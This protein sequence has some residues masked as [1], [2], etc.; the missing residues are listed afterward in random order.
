MRS[1]GTQAT[2]LGQ[3]T[4]RLS[5]SAWAGIRHPY[6]TSRCA[7][8]PTCGFRDLKN[9]REFSIQRHC[10]L[11][12]PSGTWRFGRR[13]ER[14]T[15]QKVRIPI[16]IQ[17]A[18]SLNWCNPLSSRKTPLSRGFCISKALAHARNRMPLKQTDPATPSCDP[19][20]GR[21]SRY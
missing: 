11:R 8:T 4:I 5:M 10:L 12:L 13:P 20:P 1:I 19:G 9:L 7:C 17:H 15:L 16:E 3:W 14:A 2:S 6:R 18:V 21:C